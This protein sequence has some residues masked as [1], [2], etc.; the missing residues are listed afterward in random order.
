[1]E[2]I[3][4]NASCDDYKQRVCAPVGHGS[5]SLVADKVLNTSFQGAQVVLHNLYLA[6]VVDWETSYPDLSKLIFHA[7]PR[8]HVSAV[9][10]VCA[11]C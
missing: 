5:F 2:G 8:L 4:E 9:L 1:M 3:C 10:A 11:L 6:R 7:K